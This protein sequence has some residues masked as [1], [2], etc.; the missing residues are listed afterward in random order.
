M[1]QKTLSIWM[2]TILAGLGVIGAVVYLWLVP[3]GFRSS[4]PWEIFLWVSGLPCYA[5]LFFGWGIATRIGQDRSFCPE[6]AR[7]LRNISRLAAADSAWFFAGHLVLA[8]MGESAW[9]NV[10]LSLIIVFIGC[11]ISVAAAVLSHLVLKAAALQEQSDL[12]I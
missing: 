8:I 9:G 3:W 7:G 11:A 12:T 1:N 6:N 5:V 4:L 2:K 10:L